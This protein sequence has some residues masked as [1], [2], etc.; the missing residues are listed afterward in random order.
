MWLLAFIIVRVPRPCG[1]EAEGALTSIQASELPGRLRGSLDEWLSMLRQTPSFERLLAAAVEEQERSGYLHTLREICQQPLTWIE[2]S[3]AA[4]A[5]LP[6]LRSAVSRVAGNGSMGALALTGS[7]SSVYAGECLAPTLLARLRVPAVAVPAGEV[8]TN[9]T[10]CLPPRVPLLLASLA[11][12]GNSPESCGALDSA[13]EAFP[14]C[15]H[16]VITCNAHG[17]LANSYSSDPRVQTL[18]LGEATCDRSLVMTSSFTN[19]VLAGL[20]LGDTEDA[21][22]YERCCDALATAGAWLL[23]RDAE[24]IGRLARSDYNSAVFLGSGCHFGAAR[25]SAL[26]MLEMT[27]GRVKTLAETYLGL[28]HGPMCAID[29]QTLVVCF[30][31]SDPVVRAYEL[32]LVDELAR[33]RLG[34]RKLLAGCGVP[35]ELL[36]REDVAVDF[37]GAAELAD[38]PLPILHVVVGQLLAF[39]RCLREGLRPDLP[40]ADGVISRVVGGFTLHRR[41]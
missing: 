18:V 27:S 2:T 11:R 38:A 32:D 41:A 9:P 28:R 17:R 24:A 25:E 30:L 29:E 19:M 39:F 34:A 33:K 40:S 20:L 13:L 7:G 21:R 31:S 16:L 23:L 36:S 14:A 3:G 1:D 37:A 15:Q 8:L 6:S 10:G 26:K 22:G 5:A 12:S 4:T 35:R